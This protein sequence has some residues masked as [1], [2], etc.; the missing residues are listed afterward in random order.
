[1]LNLV[2]I[3]YLK[4][5]TK[6][7]LDIYDNLCKSK[8]PAIVNWKGYHW[9]VVYKATDKEVVGVDP[10]QG[11]V[12]ISKAEFLEGWTRYTLYLEPTEQIKE[13][14]EDKPT[15]EQFKPYVKP[16][17]R[18]LW[19]ILL[20]SLAIQIFSMFLPLFTKFLL[21]E[22]ILKQ[23]TDWLFYCVGA[24]SALVLLNLTISWF[25][26]QLLLFVSMRATTQMVV[27]FYKHVLS[28]PLAFFEVRKVGDITSRFQ[29]NQKI[30]NFLTDIGLQTFLSVFSALLYFGL[31]FSLNL[32]LTLV[33]SGFLILHLINIQWVSP[34]LQRTYRDVFQ[35]GAELESFLIESIS[36]L[37]TI[38]TLSIEHWTR[39]Q[40]ENRY[41]RFTNAYLQS[42]NLGIISNLASSLGHAKTQS[43]RRMGRR[44]CHPAAG[45]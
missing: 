40:G 5:K 37:S 28:L 36:G 43:P 27:D 33:A 30:V 15:L 20:A 17:S 25:R 42:L 7:V 12:K 35:K 3:K 44:R 11:L 38:K 13:I 21:D 6:A 31:M 45:V 4:Y 39:W 26:Q 23:N 10:G 29:E 24:I 22:V 19:E 34:R 14:E 8:Q 41:L 1:M 2:K 16:Y 9:V 32:S 18:I